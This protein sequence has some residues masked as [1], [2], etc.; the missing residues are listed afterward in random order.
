MTSPATELLSL[1]R[2]SA[3]RAQGVSDTPR[4]DNEM[5]S[6]HNVALWI[7]IRKHGYTSV[8]DIVTPAAFSQLLEHELHR[9][10]EALEGLVESLEAI[11]KGSQFAQEEAETALSRALAIVKEEKA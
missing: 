7:D 9:L 11:R 5:E 3:Q 1:I 6:A 10:T 2:E 4:T 8:D